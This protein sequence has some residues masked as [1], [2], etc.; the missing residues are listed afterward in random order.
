MYVHAYTHTH[1]I[2]QLGFIRMK[3]FY[4]L[5]DII[6]KNVKGQT[7][8]WEKAF[9]SPMSEKGLVYRLHKELLYLKNKKKLKIKM[10]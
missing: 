2:D 8:E 4:V 1:T 6:K 3:L 10:I 5:K 9:V 7:T